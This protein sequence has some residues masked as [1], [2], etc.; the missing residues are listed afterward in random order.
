MTTIRPAI[1]PPDLVAAYSTREGG[2]S[3]APLGMNL[4]FKVGDDPVNVI[5]NREI[6][7]G[8]L[9]IPLECLAIPGQIHGASVRR[10]DRPGDYPDTDA[11]I[12]SATGVFLCV[13]VADCVPVLLYDPRKKTAAAVHAG[14]RGSASAV[15]LA[16]VDAMRSAY[17]TTPGDLRSVPRPRRVAIRS[18]RMSRPGSPQAS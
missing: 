18:D 14:W 13:S 17:G 5:R 16:A 6:F 7:F 10:A 4:S 1:F 3:P 11:L 15:V 9:G 12:T 2:V 8:G